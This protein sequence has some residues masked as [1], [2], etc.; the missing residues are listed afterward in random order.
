[1][2]ENYTVAFYTLGCKVN[3]YETEAI[4]EQFLKCEDGK[5]VV[6]VG[7]TAAADVF[8]INTCTVTSL[9]DRKSRQMI[10]RAIKRNPEAVVVVTGCYSQTAPEEVAQIEGVDLVVGTSDR[11]LIVAQTLG[12]LAQRKKYDAVIRIRDI[13]T[14][15]VFEPLSIDDC[16]DQTRA[17]MKIQDGCE[18]FCAYCKIPFARGPVRSRPLEDVILEAKRLV[19]AGFREIVLTG[20]HLASYGKDFKGS[21][22]DGEAS[23]GDSSEGTSL[24]DVLQALAALELEPAGIGLARIRLGSVEPRTLTAAFIGAVASLPACCPHFHVSLQSGCDRTLARMNRK[25]SAHEYADA[26]ARLRAEVPDV[27]LTTD[28]IVG[29]P[30]ET[31]DDFEESYQFV[32]D[33]GFANVHV[34]P[35]SPRKGTAAAKMTDQ[36]A[37]E[38][39]EARAARMLALATELA[40]QFHKNM[41][42]QDWDVLVEEQNHA[43]QYEGHAPNFA[44]FVFAGAGE[45]LTGKI[46]RVHAEAVIGDKIAGKYKE[47]LK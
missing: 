33:I 8:V 38:I 12:L 40:Q 7:A 45:D 39:K 47:T 36:V 23:N 10:R 2:K 35:F 21:A 9:S 11:T 24:V 28:I 32:K 6:A 15:A 37:P 13:S 4:K 30:G 18:N 29:F 20:I 17:F 25:Y 19:Q 5:F 34:F 3:Q 44:R 46:V 42:G 26:V 14:E 41:L 27:S 1:M 31:A 22:A 43:G 16:E